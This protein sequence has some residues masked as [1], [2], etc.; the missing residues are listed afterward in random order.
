MYLNNRKYGITK[1]GV[2]MYSCK[3]DGVTFMKI[4]DELSP[5]IHQ[6]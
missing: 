5:E 6:Q 2:F 4:T 1:I 3:R